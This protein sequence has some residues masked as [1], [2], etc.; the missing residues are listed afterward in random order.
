MIARDAVVEKLERLADVS[1]DDAREVEATW[2]LTL[3][4]LRAGAPDDYPI[5]AADLGFMLRH[6]DDELGQRIH[7]WAEVVPA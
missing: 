1:P 5:L 4:A 7:A 3:R 2:P 6:L